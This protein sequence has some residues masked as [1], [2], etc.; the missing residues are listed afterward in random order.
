MMGINALTVR[1]LADRRRKEQ[2]RQVMAK[3]ITKPVRWV[4]CWGKWT[5]EQ[6]NGNGKMSILLKTGPQRWRIKTVTCGIQ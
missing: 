1:R 2:I 3:T 6:D 5:I 4:L